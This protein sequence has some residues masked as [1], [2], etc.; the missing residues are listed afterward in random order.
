MPQGERTSWGAQEQIS[1][2][3][4]I[5][6]QL[7]SIHG[8]VRNPTSGYGLTLKGT[9]HVLYNARS[10]V[11]AENLLMITSANQTLW[12]KTEFRMEHD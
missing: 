6:K 7:D 1:N 5:P 8:T 12:F 3:R 11:L 9:G 4:A 10:G 2:A